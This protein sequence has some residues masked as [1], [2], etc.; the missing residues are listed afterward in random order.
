MLALPSPIFIFYVPVWRRTDTATAGTASSSFCFAG[1][2]HRD[3]E[4][5]DSLCR[6]GAEAQC[7]AVLTLLRKRLLQRQER[8]HSPLSS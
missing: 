4:S 7:L 2:A 6:D 5:L 3:L 8:R 1:G